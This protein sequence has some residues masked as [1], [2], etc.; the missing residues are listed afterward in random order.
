MCK[1][2]LDAR[3]GD[4][5]VSHDGRRMK[6][7]QI[8]SPSQIYSGYDVIGIDEAQFF[9]Q[10]IVRVIQSIADRGSRMVIAGLDK[11]HLGNRSARCRSCLP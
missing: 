5:I 8:G 1:H 7:I 11:N 2:Q 6:A 9:D 10:G 4:G 3:Y